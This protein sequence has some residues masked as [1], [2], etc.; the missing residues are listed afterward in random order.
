MLGDMRRKRGRVWYR[1]LGGACWLS[2]LTV[3]LSAEPSPPVA[4]VSSAAVSSAGTNASHRV[5][6]ATVQ[7]VFHIE[8]S[9]NRNQVH[10]AV[11]VDAGCH[12]QGAR[13]VFGYW[14]DFEVGPRATSVLLDREQVAYG[15]TPPRYVRST[16]EGGQIR[17][18]LRGFPAR[19]LTI[20][21]FRQG[22]LCAA[23][24]VTTIQNEAAALTSI[25][26]KI[27]FLFS[28]DYAILRGL[29]LVDGSAV[30]EK[31]RD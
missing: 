22:T 4:S 24:A 25:Y 27:G 11:R 28:V 21:T 30:Q 29:R 7:S 17:V 16:P 5:P 6:A 9:E 10:Y 14:R 26:V 15:L 23:R 8:K 3:P 2:L 31:M 19:P 18:S 13:P 1:A 12:P 20:D